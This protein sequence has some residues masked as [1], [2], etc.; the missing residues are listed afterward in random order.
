MRMANHAY[1]PMKKKI[2]FEELKKVILGIIKDRFKDHLYLDPSDDYIWIRLKNPKVDMSAPNGGTYD[3]L[4]EFWINEKGNIELRHGHG[5]E[6]WWIETVIEKEL[7]K[8]YN[9]K[10]MYDDG[11]GFFKIDFNKNYP[12]FRD[13]VTKVTIMGG[14]LSFTKKRLANWKVKEAVEISDLFRDDLNEQK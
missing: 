9:I 10:R 5:D 8:H 12:T 4:G 13:Y 14:K 1:I 6:G 3:V 2:T 7:A 11:V